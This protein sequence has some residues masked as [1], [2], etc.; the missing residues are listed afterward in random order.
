MSRIQNILDKAEREGA[1]RRMHGMSDLAAM[2]APVPDRSEAPAAPSPIASDVEA[3]DLSVAL[4]AAP[5]HAVSGARLDPVL[6]AALAPDATAAEQYRSLRTRLAHTD[7][8]A[9]INVV[10]ITSPGRGDGKSLTAA[11]LGLTMAQDFQ[12]R[13]CVVDAHLRHARLHELFGLP[14]S[15]GLADILSGRS[16]LA[17]SLVTLENQHITLLPAGP[18]PMHPAELL[19]SVTMRRTIEALRAQF[20]RVIIDAPAAAPLADVGILTPLVDTVLLVVHAGTTSKPAIHE[21]VAA[22]GPS[23]LLGMVLNGV[24]AA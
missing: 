21:A 20:D 19:G 15:P 5:A 14:E 9:P 2:A 3:D 1:V 12:T 6:V 10:L 22:I 13:V 11:N 24:V 4:A 7:H 16:G 8:G 23:K 18:A 17:E